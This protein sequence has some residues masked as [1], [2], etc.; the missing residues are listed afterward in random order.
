M[1]WRRLAIG[2]SVAGLAVGLLLGCTREGPEEERED[3]ALEEHACAIIVEPGASLQ[4][5]IDDAPAGAIVCL[6]EGEWTENL[7]LRSSIVLRG[8]GAEQTVLRAAEPDRPV[9][10]IEAPEEGEREGQ[11]I[12]LE[13]LSITGAFGTEGEPFGV[14]VVGQAQ[15]TVRECRVHA[16][17][18]NGIGVSGNAQVEIERSTVDENAWTGVYAWESASVAITDSTLDAN[19][20]TG[21]VLEGSSQASITGTEL[22]RNRLYG[23]YLAGS[24]QV[25][26]ADATIADNG[27]DGIDMWGTASAAIERT[28]I[29]GNEQ[30]ITVRESAQLTVEESR[31]A[32]NRG[33]GV[34]VGVPEELD[35]GGAFAGVVRGKRN[36]IP[37]P[38]EPDGNEEVAS[39]PKHSVSW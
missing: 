5:A 17:A 24:A 23:M 34:L 14:L 4:G 30:G 6:E 39:R 22:N 19:G 7:V 21:L 33:Y 36:E 35:T 18:R 9:V 25:R 3:V 28:T 31:L 15:M 1:E 20:S 10:R 38:G 12:V 11:Q 16:N 2:V 13:A 32:G 29:A 27:W 26:I 8:Q 37:G